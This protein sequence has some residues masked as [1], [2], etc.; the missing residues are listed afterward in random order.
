[1]KILKIKGIEKNFVFDA[2]KIY[3]LNIY[4]RSFYLKLL[5]SLV[6][7]NKYWIYYEDGIITDFNKNNLF[8]YDI[9]NIDPNNKK[10]LNSLY[11]RISENI[12]SRDAR[13]KIVNINNE[14]IEILNEISLELNIE[15][16]YE[17]DLDINKILSLYKLSFDDVSND[18][19][20]K[21]LTYVKANLEISDLKFVIVF[22]FLNLLSEEELAILSKEFEYLNLSLININFISKNSNLFESIT[23]DDDLCEF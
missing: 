11:K 2:G 15:T 3:N 6:N 4:N 18:L 5:Y 1:M 14:I 21:F 20:S 13:D 22:N 16:N 19:P 23:I 8:V 12:I 17:L 10:I 7:E 9:L